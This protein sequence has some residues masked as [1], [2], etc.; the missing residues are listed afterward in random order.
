MNQNQTESKP[1]DVEEPREE[2][3]DE[4]TCSPL[5]PIRNVE[6]FRASAAEWEA[7]MCFS[8]QSDDWP[9]V[10]RA[11]E[12]CIREER[13]MDEARHLFEFDEE[14]ELIGLA[15]VDV[16]LPDTATQDSASKSNNPAVSG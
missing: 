16:D 10:K 12:V 2:G 9:E 5:P 7:A 14:G 8:T 3:L 13:R 4:T 6:E 1:E 11:N 15:N